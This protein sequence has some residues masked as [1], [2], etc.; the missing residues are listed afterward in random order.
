MLAI[1]YPLDGIA[2]CTKYL[3]PRQV[4]A[5]LDDRAVEPRSLQSF[6]TLNVPVAVNVVYDQCARI[7]EA[8]TLTGTTQLRQYRYPE[9]RVA[10]LADRGLAS[11]A[12]S[13]YAIGSRSIGV[14]L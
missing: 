12:V 9:L 5:V 13:T 8:A 4:D 1:F 7:A 10:F 14:E 11:G 3:I 2:V 6:A